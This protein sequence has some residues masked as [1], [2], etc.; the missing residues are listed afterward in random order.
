MQAR[1]PHWGIE[2]RCRN[3]KVLRSEMQSQL[4]EARAAPGR[5]QRRECVKW[6]QDNCHTHHCK[7]WLLFVELHGDEVEMLLS[8]V[9]GRDRW[10]CL[11]KT[12]LMREGRRPCFVPTEVQECQKYFSVHNDLLVC[13]LGF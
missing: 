9:T 4:M 5:S 13:V 6:T 1:T 10:L 2:V 7:K 8:Q 11:L 12:D 3:W